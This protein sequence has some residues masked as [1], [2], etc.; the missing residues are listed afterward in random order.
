MAY[1]HIKA[2]YKEVQNQ[3]QSL[4]HELE[5]LTKEAEEGL[6]DPDQLEE[7][8]KTLEPLKQN[9]ERW[10]YMMY[11]LHKPVK[12]KKQKRYEEQNKSFISTL[13]PVNSI[14]ATMQ[15]SEDAIEGVRNR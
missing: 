3:Y 6:L 5:D 13:D 8:K 7:V 2:Q 14:E 9:Y 10:S 15:E 1:K 11:L 12:E 4:L